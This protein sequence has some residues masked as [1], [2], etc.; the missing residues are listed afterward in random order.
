MNKKDY[1]DK[2]NARLPKAY[3]GPV[4]GKCGLGMIG[5]QSIKL[6]EDTEQRLK[7]KYKTICD[8]CKREY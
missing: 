5:K 8:D 3:A 2:K 4:C 7:A 6:D 1:I